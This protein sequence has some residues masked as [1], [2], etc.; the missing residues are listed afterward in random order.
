MNL[1]PLLSLEHGAPIFSLALSRDENLLACGGAVTPISVWNLSDGTLVTY[2][3]ELNAPAHALAFSQDGALL[4]G[5]NIWGGVCVWQVADGQLLEQ[6]PDTKSRRTRSLVYPTTSKKSQP[7]MFTHSIYSYP[8]RSL[9]PDGKSLAVVEGGFVK[10]MKYKTTTELSK[11]NLAKYDIVK[12]GIG[13][14]VWS[15]DST[16]L[17]MGGRG[18]AGVWMPFE[19]P[20]RFYGVSLPASI[21]FDEKVVLSSRQI[22]YPKGRSIGVL[23]LPETPLLTEWARFLNSVPEPESGFKAKNDWH[24]NETQWGYDGV[25]TFDPELVWY[26]H[27]HNPHAGGGAVEQSFTSFLEDGPYLREV[28]EAILV[29]VCQA[30]RQLI[31]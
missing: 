3:G 9:A 19:H 10:V 23:E 7:V 12:G 5:V 15:G 27:S 25:H 17:A 13:K 28:P 18:W 29:K 26:N 22:L 30:V 21:A 24:W 16:R 31:R 6:K 20:P 14:M 4:A 11:I 2:L 1:N 8:D